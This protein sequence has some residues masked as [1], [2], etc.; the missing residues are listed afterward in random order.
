MVMGGD[1]SAGPD[2][3]MVGDDRIMAILL[4]TPDKQTRIAMGP[5]AVRR[6]RVK[7]KEILS[8][9]PYL[10]RAFPRFRTLPCKGIAIFGFMN[11]VQMLSYLKKSES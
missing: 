11:Q 1:H 6:I 3:I 4:K 8:S 5:C 10:R 9:H 7:L 2:R